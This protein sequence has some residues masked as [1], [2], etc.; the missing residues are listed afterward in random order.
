MRHALFF[1]I[2]V[3]GPLAAIACEHAPPVAPKPAADERWDAMSKE[4]K[5]AYMK[6]T[7][8]PRMKAIFVA[9]D[10][11]C[12]AEMRCE[13]CHGEGAE[14][15]GYAMPSADQ[16][17][18]PTPWNT[19]SARAESAPSEFDA[20]MAK[21]VAPEMARLLGRPFV[22]SARSGEGCFACHAVDR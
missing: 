16:L 12:Y 17:L 2:A 4:R 15:R 6:E 20:F 3:A 8:M 18:E 21:D 19:T 22:P 14:A 11:H 1:A 5:L 9:Y 13:T 10:P 7:V